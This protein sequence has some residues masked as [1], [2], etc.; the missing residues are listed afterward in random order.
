MGSLSSN[1]PV[2]TSLP[3]TI[4]GLPELD[5]AALNNLPLSIFKGSISKKSSVEGL[6]RIEFTVLDSYL[7]F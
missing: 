2:A 4:T 6:T 1:K 5:S 3:I 7:M